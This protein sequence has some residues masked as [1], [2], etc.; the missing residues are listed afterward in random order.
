MTSHGSE[1][2]IIRLQHTGCFNFPENWYIHFLLA[3]V[4]HS[5][6]FVHDRWAKATSGRYR[7]LDCMLQADH[8]VKDCRTTCAEYIKLIC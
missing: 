7:Q 8:G 5:E 2:I 1:S 4:N 6:F 3:R